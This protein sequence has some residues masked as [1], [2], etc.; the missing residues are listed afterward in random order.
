MP[1]QVLYTSLRSSYME[2]TTP[3]LS[4]S[5]SMLVY[6]RTFYP[7]EVKS[8]HGTVALSKFKLFSI[9]RRS[10]AMS[11]SLFPSSGVIY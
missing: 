4:F 8:T 1:Y 2:H 10:S 11:L 9:K 3:V 6:H 5:E 7:T